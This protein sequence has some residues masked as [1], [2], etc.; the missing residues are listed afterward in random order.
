VKTF[1][2]IA[3]MGYMNVTG[4]ERI[5]MVSINECAKLRTVLN[6]KIPNTID[7]PLIQITCVTIKTPVPKPRPNRDE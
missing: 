2:I 5:E 7:Y 4:I 3:T 1:L 6:T